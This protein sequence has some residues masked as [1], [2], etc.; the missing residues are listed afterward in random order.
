MAARRQAL[1]KIVRVSMLLAVL[2]EQGR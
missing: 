2:T 1:R